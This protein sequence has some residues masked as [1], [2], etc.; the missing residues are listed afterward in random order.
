LP[1]GEVSEEDIGALYETADVIVFPSHAEGFGFPCLHALATQR[2][3]LLRRLPVFEEL[4]AALGHTPNIH[5]YDTTTELVAL[6]ADPPS[7]IDAA[8]PPAGNGAERSALEIKSAL[9]LALG[10]ADFHR[11]TR[12][13]RAMQFVSDLSRTGGEPTV[14]DN[15][16]AQAAWFLAQRVERVAR[17]VFM[18]PALYKPIRALFRALRK[19]QVALRGRNKEGSG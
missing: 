11:I 4:W 2:P 3:V 14:I 15:A 6:L 1:A 18:V 8:P 16:A 12:R 10:Q 7:W 5:F 9:D 13:I 17:R 19:L